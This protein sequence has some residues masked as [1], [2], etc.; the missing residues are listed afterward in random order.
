[1][2]PCDWSASLAL[3]SL[4]SPKNSYH[5][6]LP[7]HFFPRTDEAKNASEYLNRDIIKEAYKA[8]H[9]HYPH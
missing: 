1:M 4:A 5:L 9:G 3:C 2:L 7:P 6:A 8:K